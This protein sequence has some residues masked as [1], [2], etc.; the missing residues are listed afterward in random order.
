MTI[1][2]PKST[3]PWGWRSPRIC[4]RAPAPWW[5]GSSRSWH[6]QLGY[7]WIWRHWKP[8]RYPPT[9]W[10][11]PRS[12]NCPDSQRLRPQR[13]CYQP[14]C[15][16]SWSSV[17]CCWPKQRC[18]PTTSRLRAHIQL[19]HPWLIQGEQEM[20]VSNDLLG[21]TYSPA[22]SDPYSYN[23]YLFCFE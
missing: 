18:R 13:S 3:R 2:P 8:H 19:V 5:L 17:A 14:A 12:P 1:A 23:W 20:F 7:R 16:W 11:R 10:S 4:C 15:R 9:S 6:R 22:S 21:Q